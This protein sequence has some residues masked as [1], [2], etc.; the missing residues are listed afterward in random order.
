MITVKTDRGLVGAYM[1]RSIQHFH[2]RGQEL[3]GFMTGYRAGWQI[4]FFCTALGVSAC[5]LIW[6]FTIRSLDNYE[7]AH[8]SRGEAEAQAAAATGARTI[9]AV[10]DTIDDTI[11]GVQS[12]LLPSVRNSGQPPAIHVFPTP[13]VIGIQVSNSTGALQLSNSSARQSSLAALSQPELENLLHSEALSI[14]PSPG[15]HIAR[16]NFARS[17]SATAGVGRGLVSLSVT[18]EFFSNIGINTAGGRAMWLAIIDRSGRTLIASPTLS[19]KTTERGNFASLKQAQLWDKTNFTDGR[20]RFVETSPVDGY[21]LSVLIGVDFSV[22]SEDYNAF[23]TRTIWV[24]AAG[25][26]VAVAIS[27]LL[28]G[29]LLT[30]AWRKQEV[31]ATQE[32]YRMATEGSN[33]GFFIVEVLVRSNGTIED[34]TVVDCNRTGAAFCNKDQSALVGQRFSNLYGA[35]N[36]DRIDKILSKAYLNSSFEGEVK[37]YGPGP[38][39]RW[40]FIRA[41]RSDS[42]LAVTLRDISES[43]A[44]LDELQ[45]KSTHDSL[46]GLPNRLW[47]LNYLPSTLELADESSRTVAL[48][49]IDLDGFKTANDTMGH[50]AGDELLQH[51]A[52][53]LKDAVRPHDHVIRIGGDEFVVVL[54]SNIN[55]DGA[56]AIADRIITG[57]RTAFTLSKGSHKLGASI[58]IAIFPRDGDD[59]ATLLQNADVAMYSVKTSDQKGTYRFFEPKLY[60]D[61]RSK[62]ALDIALKNAL[63]NDQFEIHYQPQLT[64][65]DAR[66]CGMEALVRWNHP[67]RGLLGPTVFISLAEENGTIIELGM[68]VLRK[69]CVQLQIWRAAGTPVESVSINVSPRQF[70]QADFARRFCDIVTE[71]G[72]PFHLIEIELTESAMMAKGNHIRDSINLLR[73]HGIKLII[74]DFGT[75]YSSLAQLQEYSFDVLKVDKAFTDRLAST[76]EAKILFGAIVA[77]AHGLGMSVVAEGVEEAAQLEILT[78]LRCDEIQGFLISRPLAPSSSQT[79]MFD[80]AIE[81]FASAVRAAG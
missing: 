18:P 63:Q 33:E 73:A 39:V 40:M 35:R 25:C 20:S 19:A 12:S 69:V 17:Y 48:L 5:A 51:V 37:F 79:E 21:P 42:R 53:R 52:H 38:L 72:A 7:L 68:L 26:V 54:Q 14:W 57:F 43:K 16:L 11:V 74:D 6:L 56:A 1:R 47:L 66:P 77:M 36:F 60:D 71:S 75:G 27:L 8:V 67:T 65:Q 24:T 45:Y 3:V 59:A 70:Q 13:G 62:A 4:V 9:A 78:E 46:T 2:S 58:G 41:V 28:I 76:A 55:D 23:R 29:F 44:H 10:I 81:N 64:I 32:T 80:N 22:E 30:L 61:L 49:F 15:N 34:F 31:T 50:A